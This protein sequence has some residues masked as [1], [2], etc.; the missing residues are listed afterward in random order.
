MAK[1]FN[2]IL[3]TTD[4][5][6][7]SIIPVPHPP[8]KKRRRKIPISFLLSRSCTRPTKKKE[9]GKVI[10]I[11]FLLSR[12]RTC[13][14]KRGCSAWIESNRIWANSNSIRFESNRI[15][16]KSNRIWSDS[17]RFEFD[18]IRF[19]L[20]SIRDSTRLDSIWLDSIQI[21]DSTRFRFET[22]LDSIQIR[23][24]T[25]FDSDLIRF[26]SLFRFQI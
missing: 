10:P 15:E 26:D 9:E 14:Q 8:Y 4:P 22:R 1:V 18:S 5:D 24:S 16:F 7:I 20:D 23:D 19:R 13:L 21:R 12:S 25:R 6:F 2:R 17:I 11:S 3:L